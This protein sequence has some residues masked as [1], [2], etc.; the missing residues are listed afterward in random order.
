MI[1]DVQNSD[2]GAL[3]VLPLAEDASVNT[4]SKAPP[5][6]KI[7]RTYLGGYSDPCSVHS[8][9]CL[10]SERTLGSLRNDG[11]VKCKSQNKA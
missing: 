2:G 3:A 7:L 9:P 6:E 10:T 4:V 5:A 11:E 8:C 1:M